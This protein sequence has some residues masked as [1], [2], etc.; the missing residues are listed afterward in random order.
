MKITTAL[1]ADAALVANGKLYIHG[2]GW[3]TIH[4]A[5]FPTTQPTMSLALMLQV[6]YSEALVDI[7]IMIELL[8]DDENEAGLKTEAK[9]NVGH[10]AG[11]K[12]GA[13]LFIPQ[14]LTLNMMPFGNP[15]QYRF[16]VSS[17]EKELA[18]VPFRLAP[19]PPGT[20][21]QPLAP[22]P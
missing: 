4:A 6:E 15:G 17:G 13:P 21:S 3:D 7:P 14:V 19:L 2:G 11:M 16:K 10:P 8:D 1:L 22:Q 12:A 20:Q 18:S 9:L 5:A